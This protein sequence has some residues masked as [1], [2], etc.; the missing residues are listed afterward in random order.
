[1]N[2]RTPT[3]FRPRAGIAAAVAAVLA[4]HLLTGAAGEARAISAGPGPLA[5]EAVEIHIDPAGRPL[6]AYQLE[7]V[8]ETG[9]A[10]IAGIEGG[11]HRAFAKPAYYDPAALARNRVILAAF[12]T[13]L[14]LPAGRTRVATL[15]VVL[16]EGATPRYR[17]R[18]EVAAD[19]GGRD[20][21]S[22]ATVDSIRR[23]V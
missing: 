5:F 17:V 19:S 21:R 18:L 1:M 14:D 12:S 16:P 6:A 8:D 15:H 20:L 9:A 23:K 22:G 11:E 4:L 2:R 3:P 10:R 13:D 7:F